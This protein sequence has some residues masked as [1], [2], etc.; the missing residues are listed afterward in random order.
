MAHELPDI[1][2]LGEWDHGICDPVFDEGTDVSEKSMEGDPK[3][4]MSSTRCGKLMGSIKN[5]E[6]AVENAAKMVFQGMER[7]VGGVV[8][9]HISEDEAKTKSS[10]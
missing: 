3:A 4:V 9:R 1:E 6:Q 7:R 2:V 10:E 5:A 8:G